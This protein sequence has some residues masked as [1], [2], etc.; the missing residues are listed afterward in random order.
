MAVP[1]VAAVAVHLRNELTV[2]QIRGIMPIK[3][4]AEA[5]RYDFVCVR[6]G[7]LQSL[8]SSEPA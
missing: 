2:R 1:L 8:E 4:P 5:R 7:M 3:D 6:A